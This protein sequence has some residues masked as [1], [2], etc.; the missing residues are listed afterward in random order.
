MIA[1][2]GSTGPDTEPEPPQTA[3]METVGGYLPH[4]Y[5][6]IVTQGHGWRQRRELDVA[7]SPGL[8]QVGQQPDGCHGGQWDADDQRDSPPGSAVARLGHDG[9]RRRSGAGRLGGAGPQLLPADLAAP[10][11]WWIAVTAG[12]TVGAERANRL[13]LGHAVT[14]RRRTWPGGWCG[15]RGGCRAAAEREGDVDA[16]GLHRG[17]VDDLVGLNVGSGRTVEQQG[18]AAVRAQFGAAGRHRPAALGAARTRRPCGRA[19]S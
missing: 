1:V 4:A 11:V 2:C 3:I 8:Q 13:G 9:G 18:V 14:R 10:A 19:H 7:L 5:P 16:G 6:A 15:P 17:L 12:R